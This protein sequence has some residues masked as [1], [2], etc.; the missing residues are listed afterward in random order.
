MNLIKRGSMSW[1]HGSCW[2]ILCMLSA[3]I[4]LLVV[5]L[6]Q[7]LPQHV[8]HPACAPGPREIDRIV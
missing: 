4:E 1:S 7:E 6:A 5:V 2:G 3:D 8:E